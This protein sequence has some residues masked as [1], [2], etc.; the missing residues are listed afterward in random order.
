VA[1]QLIVS[2]SGISDRTL[3]EVVAFRTQL[4]DRGVPASLLVAPRLNGGYRLDRDACTVNWLAAQ[5]I[6]GDAVVLHGFD[7]A[8]TTQ[9]RGE[10]ATLPAHEANLRLLAADRILAHVGLR[11]R[12][13]AAPGWSISNG[14]LTA[15]PRNGFRLAAGLRGV[16]DLVRRDTVRARVLGIGDGVMAEPWWC[17]TLVLS[18]ERTARS[19]GIVRI[20]AAARHL[21]RRGP[22]QATL[23]AIDLALMHKC[24]PAV[25]EWQ[26][27]PALTDA[28]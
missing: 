13:F 2:I 9:R 16:T 19:G 6:D 21:H 24:V 17:R 27:R 12:L 26:S 3:A 7:A 28:A 8:A 18:A 10:F 15:L 4:E 25:Y 5:R 20:A 22:R 11:T 1:G 23:D 14:A